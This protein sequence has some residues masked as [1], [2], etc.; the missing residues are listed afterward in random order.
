MAKQIFFLIQ[1]YAIYKRSTL[2]VRTQTESKE[3]ENHIPHK[4]KPKK[5]KGSDTYIKVEFK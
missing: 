1:P 4:Q 5:S 3:M 2:L